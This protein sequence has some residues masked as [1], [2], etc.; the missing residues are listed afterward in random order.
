MFD[1][2]ASIVLRTED[3]TAKDITIFYRNEVTQGF[4]SEIV[5]TGDD[6]A[7]VD[8]K[9]SRDVK[10][11]V[12]SLAEGVHVERRTNLRTPFFE[13]CLM[14]GDFSVV[15]ARLHSKL[16]SVVCNN[17]PFF[18]AGAIITVYDYRNIWLRSEGPYEWRMV[19][20][21]GG[22]LH[23]SAP[24][25]SR[26]PTSSDGQLILAP[27]VVCARVDREVL[28]SVMCDSRVVFMS[29]R[30][31]DLASYWTFMPKLQI[32]KGYFLPEGLKRAYFVTQPRE[33]KKEDVFCQC[34]DT[35]GLRDCILS[36]I[37]IPSLDLREILSG[38]SD[39]FANLQARQKR[40]CITKFCCLNYLSLS[41]AAYSIPHCFEDG[42]RAAFP[43]PK[44]EF[45]AGHGHCKKIKKR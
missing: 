45:F 3:E 10:L 34:K 9:S 11:V 12:L 30:P 5:R 21:I 16:T 35:L 44:R 27:G 39:D 22:M 8:A 38:V 6:Y 28:R 18:E 42:L 26:T 7:P 2:F 41:G 15:R 17:K 14:D 19:M 33:R 25:L 23:H 20:H 36:T 37:P 24:C 43:N 31:S 29:H 13:L 32:S 1:G 4:L 40:V